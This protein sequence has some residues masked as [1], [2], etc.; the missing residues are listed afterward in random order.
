MVIISKEH[1]IMLFENSEQKEK[2]KYED[3][4]EYF[5]SEANKKPSWG[6][7]V[8]IG[9]G[10]LSFLGEYKIE[11][12]IAVIIGLL[13]IYG[14]SL[15]PDD[16][17]IDKFVADELG[18]LKARALEKFGIEEESVSA[19]NPISFSGYIYNGARVKKGKDGKYRSDEYLATIFLFSETE[20]YSY[21]YGFSLTENNRHEVT[22]V[23]FYKDIVAVSTETNDAVADDHR[24]RYES[25]KLV[26]TGGNALSC[27]VTGDIDTQNTINTMRRFIRAKKEI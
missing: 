18:D 9:I 22:D 19:I 21:Q 17:I 12:V 1:D 7:Y 3:N 15:T 27:S 25:F 26:T 23:Y 14:S 16:S 20:L 13:C 4:E 8:L 24:F 6:W 2:S 5:K 10:V 11:G